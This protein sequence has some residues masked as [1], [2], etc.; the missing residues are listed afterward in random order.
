MDPELVTFYVV[1]P[2][3]R[4]SKTAATAKNGSPASMPIGA[5]P[6]SLAEPVSAKQTISGKAAVALMA[7]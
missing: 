6:R 4:H 7:P 2:F 5:G 1:S 3:S